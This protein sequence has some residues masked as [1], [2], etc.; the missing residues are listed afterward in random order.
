MK[1]NDKKLTL[2][3]RAKTFY[4]ASLFLP[5]NIKKDIENLYIFCRYLDD[6]GDDLNVSKINSSKKLKIIKKQ[7]KKKK[8]T[9]PI[10]RNFIDLMIKHKINDNVPIELIKGIEY[11]LKDEVNIKTFEELIKYCYQVAGTVGF[12]FCK[13]IKVKDKK[14][15]LGGIQLGIAMQLTNISRDVVEDLKMNRIY[16]PKT[17]RS[18]KNNNDKELILKNE[19]IK[20]RISEDLLVLLK[21]AEYFYE[22]AWISIK[23]LKKKYGIPISIAAELYR[24]IGRKIAKKNGN[25]WSN[26]IYVN[27]IEKIFFSL[28]TIYKLYF[29]KK[30]SIKVDIENDVILILKK[31][32]VKFN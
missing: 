5:K 27:I 31:L 17:M 13:I 20:K 16:I 7:I 15:I 22:N 12:M 18:Y 24:K 3:Y 10:I 26:R 8:S 28:V 19:N 4:F 23:T 25:I 29:S 14:L 1:I 30:I 6:L 9:F 2:K 11:D 21:Q 32:N